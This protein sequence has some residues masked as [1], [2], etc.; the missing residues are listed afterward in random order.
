MRTPVY[1]LSHGGVRLTS[2]YTD[3]AGLS[4]TAKRHVPSG[5]PGLQKARPN[6]PRD[7][8]QGQA[9][10]CGGL[11]GALAGVPGHDPGEYGRDYGFDL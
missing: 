3:T 8:D 11:L 5:P 4:I 1:F 7:Y 2:C 6:R 9:A 10:C